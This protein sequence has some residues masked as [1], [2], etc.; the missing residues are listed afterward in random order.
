MEQKI[1]RGARRG[2]RRRGFTLMEVTLAL[3]IFMMMTLVFAAVFPVAVRGAQQGNNYAQAALLAQHKVDQLRAAGF[4]KMDYADLLS[5]GVI[6]PMT[7]PPTGLPYSYTFTGVDSLVSVGTGVGATQGFYPPGSTGTLSVVD[8]STMNAAV[9][10]GQ[11]DYVTVAINWAGA[12]IS[13]GSYQVSAVIIKMVH[14]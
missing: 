5:L 1:G 7:T 9:P 3:M 6:D 8:Y 4:T 14:R 10:A 13:S 11:M 12:G 2:R